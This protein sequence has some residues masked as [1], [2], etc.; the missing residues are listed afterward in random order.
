MFNGS[1]LIYLTKNE[2]IKTVRI[3]KIRINKFK[4]TLK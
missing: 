2:K 1:I 3:I 4:S